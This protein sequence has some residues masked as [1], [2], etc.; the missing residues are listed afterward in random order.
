MQHADFWRWFKDQANEFAVQT[1]SPRIVDRIYETLCRVDKRLGI[2]ISEP[3]LSGVREMILS[4]NGFRELFSAAEELVSAAPELVGWRF[5][6]LKP[7]RGFDFVYRQD[8]Q[9]LSPSEWSFLPLRD[10]ENN[11]GLQIFIPGSETVLSNAILQTIIET[12]VGEKEFSDIRYLE[13]TQSPAAL[14]QGSWLR[15]SSLPEFLEWQ[16]MRNK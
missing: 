7:P 11:L 5:I 1:D 4:A 14:G 6:A 15:L 9:V 12:G 16:R 10:D 3:D 8:G 2:E 13:Y